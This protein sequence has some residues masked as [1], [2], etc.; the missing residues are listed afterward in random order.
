MIAAQ[1][2]GTTAHANHMAGTAYDVSDPIQRLR[3]AA[4]SCFFGEPTY[5]AQTVT[6]RYQPSVGGVDTAAAQRAFGRSF[7]APPRGGES[8]AMVIERAIDDAIGHDVEGALQCAA[9]LRNEDL[10]RTTPQVI[11]VRAAHHASARGTGAVRKWA[12]LIVRRADEPSV[13]LAY[14]LAAFPHRPL[15]NSLKRAWRGALEAQD[16]MHLAKYRGDGHNV[17]L[18]DVI[19]LTHPRSEACALAARGELKLCDSDTWEALLSSRG[20]TREAWA[21]ATNVMGHM[22]LLRNLRNLCQHGVDPRLF[23]DKLVATAHGGK[24]LPFRYFAARKALIDA[25]GAP[26]MV[27]DALERA[28]LESLGA[29][30]RISGRLAALCDNSGSARGAFTSEMGSTSVASIGNLTG[31][32][33]AK[34]ADEGHALAFGDGLAGFDV[35]RSMPILHDHE[36]LNNIGEGV[37][38]GTENGVWQFYDRAIRNHEIWDTIVILSDMQAG[39]GGLYGLNDREY[40]AYSIGGRYI[41]VAALHSMYMRTVNKDA[42]IFCIQVAGYADTLIPEAYPNAHIIG[43]WG[44]GVIRYVASA[45]Q[46]K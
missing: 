26:A 8:P 20:S 32:I 1:I 14:S 5:Y 2:V 17:K 37:G 41:D 38:Q 40:A 13:G 22:A 25:G 23:C 35:Q 43:G 19:N 27:L 44:P 28:A 45:C 4:S 12:P 9:A 36:R 11:L 31:I 3:I 30:P 6:K 21:E 24:Q 16:A 10:I 29:L 18:V 39:H 7:I 33:L 15:P 46:A 42:R 34:L